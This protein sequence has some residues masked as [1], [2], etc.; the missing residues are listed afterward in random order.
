MRCRCQFAAHRLRIILIGFPDLRNPVFGHLKFRIQGFQRGN[1]EHGLPLL[2][3][4]AKLLLQIA[5][6]DDPRDRRIELGMIDL[7]LKQVC[8][9]LGSLR[10]AGR[11]ICHP[12]VF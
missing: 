7:I 3:R 4:H 11:Y 5:C 1:F 10:D 9:R 8:L 2:N 12:A 6:D